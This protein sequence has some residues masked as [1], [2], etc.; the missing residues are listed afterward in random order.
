MAQRD[1][2]PS[3]ILAKMIEHVPC[4]VFFFLCVWRFLKPRRKMA[5]MD[6]HRNG[7]KF[8][9]SCPLSLSFRRR[10]KGLQRGYISTV[11]QDIMF[12][13]LIKQLK[14]SSLQPHLHILSSSALL[15]APASFLA[16]MH[17]STPCFIHRSPTIRSQPMRLSTLTGFFH[18]WN[19]KPNG[20]FILEI[21]QT[22]NSLLKYTKRAERSPRARTKIYPADKIGKRHLNRLRQQ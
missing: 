15:R 4:G 19:N 14:Q 12:T 17:S 18:C 21:P 9:K 7:K 1:D 2:C 6:G 11:H 16:L 5:S 8:I 20:S 3:P 10:D 22:V 13:H